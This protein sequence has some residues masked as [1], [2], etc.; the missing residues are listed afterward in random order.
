V[1]NKL[2]A[3]LGGR[4]SDVEPG[5]PQP[6][7]AGP[8]MPHLRVL[9]DDAGWMLWLPYATNPVPMN[10]NGSRKT[11]RAEARAVATVRDTAEVLAQRRI[12]QQQRIRVRLDWEVTTKRVRDED[13]LVKCMKHL[14]DGLRIAGVVQDDTREFVERLMPEINLAPASPTRQAH[15][16]LWI[17][18]LPIV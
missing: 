8:P 17:W 1:S 2:E 9:D 6:E 5:R 3:A 11:W 7:W 12:P 16:R 15:M 18:R 13:N 4:G 14:V 10:R